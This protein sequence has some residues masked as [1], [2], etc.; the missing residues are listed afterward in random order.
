[1]FLPKKVLQQYYWVHNNWFN[2]LMFHKKIWVKKRKVSPHRM[3]GTK[4][5]WVRN[6]WVHE[7]FLVQSILRAQKEEKQCFKIFRYKKVFRPKEYLRPKTIEF[8]KKLGSKKFWIKKRFSKKYLG[9][10]K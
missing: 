5:F 9:E 6:N 10:K 3:L 7:N 8:K 4:K 2:I 1:M